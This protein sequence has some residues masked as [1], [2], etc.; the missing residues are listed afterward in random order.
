[1]SIVLQRGQTKKGAEEALSRLQE[2]AREQAERFAPYA[3]QAKEAAVQRIEQARGWTAPRLHSAAQRVEDT[4]APRVA[5]LLS[6]AAQK[7]DP[8]PAPP[9]RKLPRALVYVGAGVLG[10]AAVYAVLRLRQAARDARVA[11]PPGERPGAGA[12]DPPAA[13]CASPR[14]PWKALGQPRSR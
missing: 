12:S 10:L 13:R 3:A 2:V 1:M 11:R 9:R 7:V 4:V 14:D 6:T 8:A 5:E